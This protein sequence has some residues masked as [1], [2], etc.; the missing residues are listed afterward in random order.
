MLSGLACRNIANLEVGCVVVDVKAKTSMLVIKIMA[1]M[2]VDMSLASRLAS[3]LPLMASDSSLVDADTSDLFCG[4]PGIAGGSTLL[5]AVL[6]C[7]AAPAVPEG[8]CS[9][10]TFD[11]KLTHF[12]C[13]NP[14]EAGS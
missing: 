11:I 4:Q 5:K 1:C 13:S 9:A 2:S 3:R 8:K 12:T 6:V 14:G 10:V 7:I